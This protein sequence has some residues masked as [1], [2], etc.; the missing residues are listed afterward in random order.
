MPTNH[1]YIGIGANLGHALQQVTDAIALIDTKDTI[2]VT[3]V[4][5]LYKTEPIDSS[6]DDYINAVFRVET[7]LDADILL[8]LLFEI[9]QHFGRE[10]PYYNAPRTLDLDLLMFNDEVHNTPRLTLPH[11]RM[12]ERAFVL[13]PLIEIAPDI[14]IPGKGSAS[15][16][17]DDVSNQRI[18]KL[19]L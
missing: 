10:R 17:V 3:A 8:T 2:R 13:I 14:V 9:E 16:F 18:Q 7:S 12:H 5:S 4:S 6:G 15:T 11:P 19:S 1:A